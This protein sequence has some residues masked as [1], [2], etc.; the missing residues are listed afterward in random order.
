MN[1][2]LHMDRVRIAFFQSVLN[3]RLTESDLFF[4]SGLVRPLIVSHASE[5]Y[6]PYEAII[7]NATYK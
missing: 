2:L 3:P 7:F 1:H 6:S 5:Q 4:N